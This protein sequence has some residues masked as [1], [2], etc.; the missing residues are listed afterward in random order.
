MSDVSEKP[1][2]AMSIAQA[3]AL[4]TAPGSRLEMEEVDIRGVPTRVWKNAPP[5]LR[6]V[7]SLSRVYGTREL[8]VY[9]NDRV[10]FEAFHRAVINLAHAMQKMGVE[11][12]DRVAIIMRNLPEWPV[13]FYAAEI[14]GAIVTPLNAWW[15]GP[16]LEY[17]LVDSGSEFA[18]IDAERLER[19]AEHLSTARTSSASMSAAS[20]TTCRAPSSSVSRTWSASPTTGPRCRTCRCPTSPSRPTTMPRS[21]TPRGRP[22]KP[23]GALGTHR[24]LNSNIFASAASAARNFLRRGEPVPARS[25]DRAATL[26]AA[27]GA[28]LPCH[29]LLCRA[30]SRRSSPAASSC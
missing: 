28:V 19:I 2:P 13:I 22:G 8:I 12:G 4:L 29:G 20:T 6:E 23:K 14:I 26:H 11:Q 16:E 27:L 1:W 18:F 15:T 24:N 5:T 9:E 21:S 3:H 10:T 17:G 7:V 25:A 30:R